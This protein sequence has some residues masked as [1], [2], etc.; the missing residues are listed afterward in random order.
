[1]WRAGSRSQKRRRTA[2]QRT[3]KK[4]G[5][6]DLNRIS[7]ENRRTDRSNRRMS[8]LWFSCLALLFLLPPVSFAQAHLWKYRPFRANDTDHSGGDHICDLRRDGN[9]DGKPDR[10]GNYVTVAGTVIAG[11]STFEPSGRLFWI[12]EKRCGIPVCGGK[13]GL[14]LG[15]SVTAGGWV[16][17][18]GVTCSIPGIGLATICDVALANTDITLVSSGGS[19]QPVDVPPAEYAR[20]PAG[21]AGN[22]VKLAPAAKVSRVIDL[23]GNQIAWASCGCGSLAVYLHS[24]TH[25]FVTQGRCYQITGIVTRLKLPFGST[26]T[27]TWCVVP[28]S[29]SDISNVGCSTDCEST[30][31]GHMKSEFSHR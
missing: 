25:C 23:D 15:D 26:M 1:V 10:L 11:P 19:H 30:S 2:V 18:S 16:N 3:N 27:R 28:R 22:L 17:L 29:P 13:E 7:T 5:D 21:Y 6:R 14:R 12:R 8:W 20:D 31:W 24:G 9:A 4:Y